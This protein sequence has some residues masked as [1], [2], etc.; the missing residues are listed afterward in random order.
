MAPVAAAMGTLSLSSCR[1]VSLGFKVANLHI[2]SL[3]R[4][5]PREEVWDPGSVKQAGGGERVP[6]PGLEGA[7][8]R[9]TLARPAFCP[10]DEVASG[11]QTLA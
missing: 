10:Q 7:A 6:T 1:Q 5:F 9:S 8:L 11:L 4:A 2:L 3:P